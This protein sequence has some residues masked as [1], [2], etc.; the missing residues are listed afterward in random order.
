M[1][2]GRP[3]GRKLSNSVTFRL[4][5]DAMAFLS[6][7]AGEEQRP[8]AMMARLLLNEALAARERKGSPVSRKKGKSS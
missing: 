2:R 8:I 6:R 1:K 5:D 4:D 3:A 7:L